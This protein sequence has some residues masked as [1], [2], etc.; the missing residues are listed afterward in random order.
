MQELSKS[1]KARTA[2][3]TFKTIADALTLQGVY[4]P[5][6]KTGE[7]LAEA[8]KMLSPEIYGS[9]SDPRIVELKGLEYVIDRMPCGVEGCTRL[10]LTA[11]EDF[12]DTAFS[13]IVPLK[14]RRVSYAVSDK[15]MCFVITHGLS[16]IYDIL[17]HITFLNIEAH[18]IYH[19]ACNRID[20][21]TPEWRELERLVQE[22]RMPEGGELDQAIWNLSIILGRTY[23]ETRETYESLNANHKQYASNN[24]LFKIVYTIGKRV[25]D[26]QKEGKDELTV[27]FTPSLREMIGQHTY[28]T[29]WA[30]SLKERLYELGFKERP[31]HVISANMHSI[32][33]IL[34]GSGALLAKGIDVP[35]DLYQMV[36]LIRSKGKEVSAYAAEH[37]FVMHKDQ[38]GSNID[39]HIVDTA[40][41]DEKTLHPSCTFDM[42]YVREH[43]PVLVVMDY[44]FGT[45]A[46]EVMDELLC[47]CYFSDKVVTYQIESISVMGKA[48][49]LPGRKGDIMLATAHVM[50]GTPHNY[51]VQND[52]N[53]ADFENGVDVYSGPMV[54]VLGTSLQ[55]RDV[56]ERFHTSNWKAVGLEMEGGHYQRAINAAIIQGHINPE[57]KTRYAYYAS[58]NPLVSGQTLASGPMGEEGIVP[59]YMIS[60]VIL[61]KILNPEGRPKK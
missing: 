24:G 4:T 46:F 50:E 60:R 59:T 30:Q 47:P 35:E 14:R 22:G 53:P 8:L 55:N 33:N 28:A 21:T 49:I 6:G 13:K 2:I 52:L 45:Q 9:M 39:V 34:Y 40:L 18:K 20:G 41:I 27:Y 11:Q 51:I 19:Q 36:R 31:L 56:L 16:E 5:S 3:R 61:E 7:K 58:D 42:E 25:I 32:R 23:K 10:I 38:S 12:Q 54:T 48:G 15:E 57:M 43:K 44:A 17:T 26:E 1:Q 37:G 29:L